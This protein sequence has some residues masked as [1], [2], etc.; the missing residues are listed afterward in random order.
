M[1]HRVEYSPTKRIYADE[2]LNIWVRVSELE[3]SLNDNEEI[4]TSVFQKAKQ[5]H[6]FL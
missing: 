5:K 1:N 6:Q 4:Y 2:F 3:S